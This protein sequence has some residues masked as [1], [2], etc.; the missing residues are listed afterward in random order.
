MQK[1]TKTKQS[2]IQKKCTK[3]FTMVV[4]RQG[5]QRDYF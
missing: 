5:S 4:L 3:R 1:E 2:K